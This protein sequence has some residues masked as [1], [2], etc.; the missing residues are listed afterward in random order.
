MCTPERVIVDVDKVLHL[1]KG[2][3]EVDGCG[4]ERGVVDR[5]LE[6]GVLVVSL[7]CEK[8]HKSVWHSSEVL[9]EKR[10]QNL[11]VNFDNVSLFAK[12]LNL[13]CVSIILYQNPDKLC[14]SKHKR[15]VG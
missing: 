5:K 4:K 6:G 12:C 9:A 3:C 2:F 8:G 13:N 1:C 14:N 15:S 10:G 11:Y 7:C